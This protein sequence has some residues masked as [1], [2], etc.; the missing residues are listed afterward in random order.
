MEN[1]LISFELSRGPTD[2]QLDGPV[3]IQHY[4]LD[5]NQYI[6]FHEMC[7][8]ES[9]TAESYFNIWFVGRILNKHKKLKMLIPN[10]IMRNKLNILNTLSY[11]LYL[12]TDIICWGGNGLSMQSNGKMLSILLAM[13]PFHKMSL[14]INPGN[15]VLMVSALYGVVG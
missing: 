1:A 3:R 6:S 11:I 5:Y 13:K 8:Q 12:S 7:C 10:I 14:P 4:S 2:C 9:A 15:G